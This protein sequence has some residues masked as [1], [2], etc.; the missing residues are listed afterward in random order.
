MDSRGSFQLHLFYLEEAEQFFL[1]SE[2]CLFFMVCWP[3]SHHCSAFEESEM[4]VE[5]KQRDV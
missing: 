4:F 2:N 1:I 3:P 5:E